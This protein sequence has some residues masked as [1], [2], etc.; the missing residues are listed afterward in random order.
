MDWPRSGGDPLYAARLDSTLVAARVV[1][2]QR[3]GADERDGFEAAVGM[4]AGTVGLA[5][6]RIDVDRDERA[7][8]RDRVNHAHLR[9]SPDGSSVHRHPLERRVATSRLCEGS[10]SVSCSLKDTLGFQWSGRDEPLSRR[11]GRQQRPAEKATHGCRYR[12]FWF[13][14]LAISV[15]PSQTSRMRWS[16]LSGE[17]IFTKKACI[18]DAPV[19]C[20]HAKRLDG[21]GFFRV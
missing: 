18:A 3:A 14:L 12:A 21:V 19:I 5:G 10:L 15:S 7:K 6:R 9:L 8:G 13:R 17:S 1:M 11:D 20:F 16:M 2:R 4:R